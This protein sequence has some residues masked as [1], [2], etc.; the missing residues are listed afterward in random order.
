MRVF[1]VLNPQYGQQYQHGP[2]KTLPCEETTHMMSFS[3]TSCMHTYIHPYDALSS[4][5]RNPSNT[6]NHFANTSLGTL[7]LRT[8]EH[9]SLTI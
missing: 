1:G 4:G 6:L 8:L 3:E 2:K 5:G 9:L 7:S